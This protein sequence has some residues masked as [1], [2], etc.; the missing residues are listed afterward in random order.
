[1]GAGA[2]DGVMMGD[3]D[4]DGDGRE[5]SSS[6]T[7]SSTTMHTRLLRSDLMGAGE[8]TPPPTQACCGPHGLALQPMAKELPLDA[9]TTA[10]SSCYQVTASTPPQC[11]ASFTNGNRAPLRCRHHHHWH[12]LFLL[13]Y[14]PLLLRVMPLLSMACHCRCYLLFLLL[15]SKMSLL[16]TP[17]PPDASSASNSPSYSPCRFRVSVSVIY[18][19]PPQDDA[20]FASG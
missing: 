16:F 7:S 9:T 4:G 6:S 1:M 2:R 18:P 13:R 12:L 15:P 19:P 5:G 20:S 11:D 14:S 17:L 10:T 8:I 3:A